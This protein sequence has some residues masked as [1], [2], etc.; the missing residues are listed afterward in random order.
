M[1]L[2]FIWI[3]LYF[4]Y[5]VFVGS[6]CFFAWFVASLFLQFSCF[7]SVYCFWL[8]F[9]NA[10]LWATHLRWSESNWAILENIK[11]HKYFFSQFKIWNGMISW[12]YLPC[13]HGDWEKTHWPL[14]IW[15]PGVETLKIWQPGVETGNVELERGWICGSQKSNDTRSTIINVNISWHHRECSELM[16]TKMLMLTSWCKS[17][18]SQGVGLFKLLLQM[19]FLTTG[20]CSWSS[21]GFVKLSLPQVKFFLSILTQWYIYIFWF[22][23][24]FADWDIMLKIVPIFLLVS[25]VSCTFL[26]SKYGVITGIHCWIICG[27]EKVYDMLEV[28]NETIPKFCLLEVADVQFFLVLLLASLHSLL[29]AELLKFEISLQNNVEKYKNGVFLVAWSQPPTPRKKGVK[30]RIYFCSLEHSHW[31]SNIKVYHCKNIPN[32]PIGNIA[33]KY[34]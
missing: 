8:H 15:Q 4:L 14:K 23:V 6:L 10:F 30:K 2:F 29:A 3:R 21:L 13:L 32:I 22:G 28:G 9:D 11:K 17:Y 24:S 7:F 12:Q 18:W 26:V 1:F 16:L 34:F 31:L 19:P 5:F 25:S 33:K 20:M 27:S